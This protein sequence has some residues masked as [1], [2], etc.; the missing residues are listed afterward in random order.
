MTAKKRRSGGKGKVFQVGTDGRGNPN[1]RPSVS[2]VEVGSKKRYSE[3]LISQACQNEQVKSSTQLPG[4]VLRPLKTQPQTTTL[5]E[6]GVSSNDIVDLQLM[7]RAH[8][9]ALREHT[10][11]VTRSCSRPSTKH[12]VFLI[13][14]KVGQVGF[15]TSIKFTCNGCRFASKA[16]KLYE[17]T[18]TGACVTNVAAGAA[19]SKVAIKPSDA[20]FFLSSLNVNGPCRQTLQRHFSKSCSVAEEILEDA[21]SSNRGTVHDYLRLVGRMDDT[22]CPSASVSLDGQFNRPVYHGWD[23]KSTTVSEPVMENETGLNLVVSHAVKSKLD[24]T[25]DNNKVPSVIAG[26]INHFHQHFFHSKNQPLHLAYK[27]SRV[28]CSKERVS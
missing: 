20:S 2:L 19:L 25:Y 26:C 14:K 3:Q 23:G 5:H 11:Y 1:G 13:S 15:G 4:V 9:E 10:A 16:F 18:T 21:V 17:S 8:S 22:A 12:T 6:Q 28:L 7:N 27:R 24:G